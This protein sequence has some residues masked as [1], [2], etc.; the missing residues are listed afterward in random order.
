MKDK[1]AKVA[2]LASSVVLAAS[3]VAAKDTVSCKVGKQAYRFEKQAGKPL[4]AEQAKARWGRDKDAYA[5]VEWSTLKRVAPQLARKDAVKC[6]S[7]VFIKI[8][9][10]DG[11]EWEDVRVDRWIVVKG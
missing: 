7:H 10:I 1:S 11:V 3:P 2:L 4:S 6:G 5:Q 9:V 8:D